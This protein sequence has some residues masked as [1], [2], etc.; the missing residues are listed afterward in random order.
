MARGIGK[1]ALDLAPLVMLAGAGVAL[2]QEPGLRRAK[3]QVGRGRGARSPRQIPA[4]GWKDILLRTR[5]EF[6]DDQIPMIAAGV[7][8][9]TLLAIFPGLGAFVALYGLFADVAVA[10]RHLQLLAFILP[11]DSLRF[12]G[13]EM[14]RLASANTGGLSLAFVVGLLVSIWSANGAVKSLMTGLNIA[15]EEHEQRG[16]LRRTLTSLAFTLG[17][18]V[19][20]ISAVTILAA[21]PAIETFIG[22]HAAM[23]FG[24][25]SWPLLLAGLTVG[26]ALLYR[27]GPSRDPVQWK[28]I[29]WGSA[30]AV[31][32]WV[33]V[34]ALFSLYVSNFAHYDRTYGSLGTVVGFM[35]WL[36][37][38]NMVVLGGA[39]L[40]AEIEHQT[41]VDTT[42]GAPKPLGF[43]RAVMADTVGAAQAR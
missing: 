33:A 21:G 39:E 43:R 31:L 6:S 2:L 22:P 24:W 18:L 17:F 32:L 12:I 13:Q 20:G 37:L 3:A 30:A 26:L 8:F 4:R 5:K 28:W 15:Y 23:V 10:Q 42:T 16:F 9:Y 25:I 38:S 19:F 11:G 7:T 40:N 36:W 14:I 34:S 35:T 29:S 1:F 41:A 27:F